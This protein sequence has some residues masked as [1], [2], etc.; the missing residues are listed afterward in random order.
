MLKNLNLE[1]TYYKTRHEIY[2]EFYK[3]CMENSIFYDRIS[4]YFGSS[5][6]IVINDSLLKFVKNGGKIRIITSPVLTNEDLSAIFDGYKIKDEKIL[7]E[8]I[9][10]AIEE[11]SSQFPKATE[12]LKVLIASGVIDLKLAQFGDNPQANRLMHDK[13]GIF[14]DRIG[15]SVA[16]RGSFNETF[17]G[18]SQ[19]GNGESFDVFTNWEGTKDKERVDNVK[20]QF[21]SMW[22]DNEPNIIT[23]NL[24]KTSIEKIKSMQSKKELSELIDEVTVEL[25]GQKSKWYAEETANR[26]T[27]RRHQEEVLN[28]WELNN[29]KGLFEMST[30]S[31]KTF[32]ALCAIRES[33]FDKDEIPIIIVPSKLLFDQWNR[34]LF[35]IFGNKVA[36]LKVGSGY[37]LD[38]SKL[39]LYTKENINIKRC[40]LTTYQTSSKESFISS[41]NWSNKIF[42]ICDEVHNIGSP[43]Y[44]NLL[45]TIVGPRI[46]LSA[47]PKR[48]NEDENMKILKFFDK[49]IE[50]RYAISD[51]IKDKVLCEYFYEVFEVPLRFEEQEKWL[52]LTN[53]INKKFA[54]SKS[55][56]SINN[57]KGIEML[58]FERADIIKKAKNKIEIAAKI[59]NEKYKPDQRWLVY[60]DDTEQVKELK[61]KL[62][63]NRILRGNVF[64][65]H[66]NSEN[67]LEET[68]KHFEYNGAVLLSINCLDEGVDIPAVDNAIILS[69]SK[70]PRQ[71]IQRRGRVLRTS[72]NK[73]FA[74]IYDCIVIPEISDEKEDKFLSIIKGEV[75]RSLEF[76]KNARN[77]YIV[78]SKILQMMI[79]N[80]ISE[81]EKEVGE[82]D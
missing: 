65:Y 46:G 34:E 51:A 50:P 72:K 15:N 21:N 81:N 24:P 36:V 63:S 70:N 67:S 12:L 11:L 57:L 39:D 14:T 56:D 13:A 61:T 44:Q 38:K 49:I 82:D 71:Y 58:L 68:I 19:F 40:I 2:E 9:E 28:N 10:Y 55:N 59:L 41:I 31:G 6:F 20:N 5:I 48:Y 77:S 23:Y 4:G 62:E 37:Q 54:I 43:K 30:G 75:A 47:T 8:K 7:A 53:Q 52:K 74:Y 18:L 35:N 3:P 79:K 32:T 64:E 60:L 78:E 45:D 25:M 16:F 29:R 22:C 76:S 69:S 80:N 42:L 27:I 26:R 73:N 66:T 1:T 33:I 17:K